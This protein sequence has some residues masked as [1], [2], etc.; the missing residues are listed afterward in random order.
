MVMVDLCTPRKATG[1]TVASLPKSSVFQTVK[2][3]SFCQHFGPE[4][5]EGDGGV[6]EM[7]SNLC[8]RVF[9]RQKN[10]I[11]KYLFHSRLRGTRLRSSY[12]YLLRVTESL[13]RS[14]AN[15]PKRTLATR[16]RSHCT[17]KM[18]IARKAKDEATRA[19]LP[20]NACR[21]PDSSSC[22]SR[23]TQYCSQA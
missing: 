6:V 12:S 9:A 20:N 21:E 15:A 3:V 10:E 1:C 8:V 18:S 5:P 22:S 17:S 13:A 2:F 4:C 7:I 11:K 23:T 19:A 14:I 16:A